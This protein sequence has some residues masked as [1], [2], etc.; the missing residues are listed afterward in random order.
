MKI[1]KKSKKPFKSGKQV[2]V[3]ISE[4]INPITDKEAYILADCV[5]DKRI[6]IVVEQ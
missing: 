2:E 3:V 5:V 1:M 6:C 4:G